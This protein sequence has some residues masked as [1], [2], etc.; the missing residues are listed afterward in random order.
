MGD[1]AVHPLHPTGSSGPPASPQAVAA[2]V[3]PHL[4]GWLHL[5]MA[6]VALAAGI[7]L[8]A[9]CP[10]AAARWS[11]AVFTATAVLLFGTSAVYHRGSWSG[12]VAGV[13]KR[14]DHSNIFLIIAGTYTPFALVLPAPQGRHLLT[15][16]WSGA[17]LG[18]LFRVL[19][20]GAPRWLYTPVYVLLGWVA[21]FYLEPLLRYGG[22][23]MVTLVVIGGA[24]Y[25]L[26]AVVYATKRPNPSARWFGFHE[27][28]H[29][30]TIAGFTAHYI[31]ASMVLYGHE[32]A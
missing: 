5:G 1:M 29:A 32:V 25:T 12:R 6:P 20:V 14:L 9:L 4:R 23:T 24:C 28:F 8:V 19:W 26:G 22:A 15:I 13:L 21:V 31:A 16:V 3:K 30:L 2:L 11:A 7:A 10:T 27:I 17:L 18:V